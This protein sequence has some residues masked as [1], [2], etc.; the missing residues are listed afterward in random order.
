MATW[1]WILL[2]LLALGAGLIGGY[3]F[4]RLRLDAGLQE[5]RLRLEAAQRELGERDQ[6]DKRFK[7]TFAALSNQ[8]LKISS[9]QFLQLAEE[10]FKALSKESDQHLES[11]KKLIDA[12]LHQMGDTLKDLAEKSTKLEEGLASSKEQT[13]KLRTTAEKLHKVLASPQQRGKWG[14]R[15]VEDILNILGMIKG[16]DYTAQTTVGS[17]ARPDYT[18]RLPPDKKINL[19][20]K[21][22]IDQYERFLAADSEFEREEAKK[23][24]L[25]QV[26]THLKD[27]TT[28]EY[29]DP[30]G[31]TVDYVIVFIPN[32]SVYGFI[33][34]NDPEMLD[35][36]L[37]N[38]IILCSPITLYAVIS[39]VRKAV[40]TFAMEERTGE[41]MSLLIQFQ[42]QWDKYVVEMEKMG[43]ALDRAKEKYTALVNT[44]TNQL[45]KPLRKIHELQEGRQQDLLAGS[46][47]APPG[48]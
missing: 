44:R 12:N 33:H 18:F 10:K 4:A 17:G 1:V 35:Y 3:L 7:D 32:E 46:G 31:G 42:K 13:E 20:V 36:A 22:P 38:H 43:G 23:I 30:V 21:F 16:I 39:L 29:I 5:A 14:E 24:F 26:R 48:D 37:G 19:D 15:L 6:L 2:V 34:Q 9:D 47:A 40:S 45:E 27:V 11:K 25:R 8:A 28:R 41:F